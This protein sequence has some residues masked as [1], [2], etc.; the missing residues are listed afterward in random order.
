MDKY[1]RWIGNGYQPRDKVE[2]AV[3]LWGDV[4]I[5]FTCRSYIHVTS[6][7]WNNIIQV[8]MYLNQLDGLG[9]D[10]YVT[11]CMPYCR[12]SIQNFFRK[13]F[14]PKKLWINEVS[15]CCA[16]SS[17]PLIK[18]NLNLLFSMSYGTRELSAKTLTSN[19]KYVTG[20]SLFLKMAK[21]SIKP[22]RDSIFEARRWQ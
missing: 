4:W 16:V 12:T 15:Q 17:A 11:M 14:K 20:H 5:D 9:H 2:L 18:L 22:S 7:G 8:S 3:L 21:R 13:T 1:Q 19:P 10:D 6:S